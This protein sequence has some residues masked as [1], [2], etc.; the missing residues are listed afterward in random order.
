MP[1]AAERR[2][3]AET[4]RAFTQN[5]QHAGVPRTTL[6]RDCR[7]NSNPWRLSYFSRQIHGWPLCT[8][9]IVETVSEASLPLF[10]KQ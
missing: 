10:I 7:A 3:E 9:N 8:K 1:R 2:C 6:L 4:G 5:R